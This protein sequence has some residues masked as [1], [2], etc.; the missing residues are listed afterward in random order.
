MFHHHLSQVKVASVGQPRDTNQKTPKAIIM[1]RYGGSPVTCSNLDIFSVEA[2]GRDI[3]LNATPIFFGMVESPNKI[4]MR[5]DKAAFSSGA[6]DFARAHPQY[7][8]MCRVDIT[9][10][11]RR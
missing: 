11:K 9:S 1:P 7:H 4:L 8:D 5:C 3:R 10:F 2:K 6:S